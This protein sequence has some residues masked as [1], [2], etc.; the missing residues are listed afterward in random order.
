MSVAHPGDRAFSGGIRR[1]EAAK[2]VNFLADGDDVFR[3]RDIVHGT[4][5]LC[6][7]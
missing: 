2:G 4:S 7:S 5:R 6:G 3:L 1:G